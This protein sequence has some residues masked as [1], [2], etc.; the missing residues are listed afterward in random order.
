MNCVWR[1]EC[2][3]MCT[4]A[5]NEIEMAQEAFINISTKITNKWIRMI[6]AINNG[7][8]YVEIFGD[9][10]GE[11]KRACVRVLRVCVSLHRR[12]HSTL[13]CLIEIMKWLNTL[14]NDDKMAKL[15][16]FYR[17][18]FAHYTPRWR[19]G[20]GWLPHTC[21]NER[22][23]L[24]KFI[25]WIKSHKSSRN[26][27][28]RA[29]LYIVSISHFAVVVV[30]SC[31]NWTSSFEVEML[32]CQR[33]LCTKWVFVVIWVNL[34][35][36]IV[37]NNVVIVSITTMST[38]DAAVAAAFDNQ[39]WLIG[40]KRVVHTHTSN[41]V[42][43]RQRLR[44]LELIWSVGKYR[45]VCQLNDMRLTLLTVIKVNYDMALLSKRPYMRRA[46]LCSAK[47]ECH[48]FTLLW[49]FGFELIGRCIDIF[50]R[51]RTFNGPKMTFN[52]WQRQTKWRWIHTNLRS[53]ATLN[54]VAGRM[55][56]NSGGP[57]PS[58]EM[59]MGDGN[60]IFYSWMNRTS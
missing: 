10:D 7:N 46:D 12:W 50:P 27:W 55:L 37:T 9:N 29:S 20:V 47:A 48:N 21:A 28:S 51:D 35:N 57:S 49:L 19:T 59:E 58:Q 26:K 42:K 17:S 16:L 22:L 44:R 15:Q 45:N 18:V 34:E 41:A 32:F 54:V 40:L 13:F 25:V 43:R 11:R 53:C 6:N 39:N 23:Y 31:L 4:V 56:I 24:V 60:S 1:C 33:Y 36:C 2:E 38:N 5:A 3:I 52:R 30:C 8:I 14:N